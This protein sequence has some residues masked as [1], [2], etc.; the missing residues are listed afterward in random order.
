MHWIGRQALHE[1]M[2]QGFGNGSVGSS[3]RDTTAATGKQ[4]IQTSVPK[5]TGQQSCVNHGTSPSAKISWQAI[6]PIYR[7]AERVEHQKFG[8]GEVM[9]MEGSAH[10]PIATVKFELNGREK[11]HAELR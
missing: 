6:P 5:Y 3:E 10:N 4:A 1:R 11:N 2:N 8:F 7:L 9:K